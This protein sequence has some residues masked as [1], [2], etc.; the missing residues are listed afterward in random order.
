[1]M[2]ND[3]NILVSVGVTTYDR[4]EMLAETL[5]SIL[6]QSY[7]NL[8]ILVANDNPAREVTLRDLRLSEDHRIK[9]VNHS[10]N[11]GEINNLNWLLEN[12]SGKYFTWLADDDVVHPQH[13]EILLRAF[14][15]Q[16]QIVATFSGYSSVVAKFQESL[17]I[18]LLTSEFTLFETNTFL[19][20]YSRRKVSIIGC[21]GLFERKSLQ[22]TGGFT[23]LGDSFSPYSDTLL[24]IMLCKYGKVSVTEAST[25]LFRD[26]GSSMSNSLSDLNAFLEAE[27]DFFEL[28]DNETNSLPSPVRREIFQ[29]F[30][31]WFRH[32]HI[33]V[34]SRVQEN[35]IRQDYSSWLN[36]CRINR[37]NLAN[38]GYQSTQGFLPG[39]LVLFRHRVSAWRASRL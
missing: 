3:Q 6:G 10:K 30:G 31:K 21:Y 15:N 16:T 36:A 38:F 1:M 5:S 4:L 23:Y 33:S 27:K 34:I 35:G 37:K 11:L 19:L 12:S 2:K 28:L 8:E 29:N 18:D 20:E 25:V 32:N 26:H 7:Q 13:I 9:I 17:T 24:P 39:M 22:L 14:S